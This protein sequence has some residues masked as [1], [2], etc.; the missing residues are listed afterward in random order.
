MR[1][2]R[3]GVPTA[4]RMRRASTAVTVTAAVDFDDDDAVF[5]ARIGFNAVRVGVI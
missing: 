4:N 3:S 1:T 5:L 2:T